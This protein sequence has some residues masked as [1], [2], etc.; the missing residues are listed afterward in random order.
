[1]IFLFIDF[2]ISLIFLLLFIEIQQVIWTIPSSINLKKF[3][4]KGTLL[5][6]TLLPFS[7]VHSIQNILIIW[8]SGF[9][10]SF[11]EN[12]SGTI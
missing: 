4:T 11:R 2:R 9:V 10:Q 12:A 5:I 7:V 6:E 3:Y 1:M 8:H